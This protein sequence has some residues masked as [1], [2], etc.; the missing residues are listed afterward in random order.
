VLYEA[1][2]DDEEA[3]DECSVDDVD[4]CVLELDRAKS[5]LAVLAE[6]S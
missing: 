4:E 1:T 3:G 5:L 2:D 6:T